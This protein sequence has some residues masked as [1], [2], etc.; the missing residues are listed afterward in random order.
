MT[1][2]QPSKPPRKHGWRWKDMTGQRIGRLVVVAEVRPRRVRYV[3]TKYIQT[4]TRW[5]CRCDC[6]KT[7]II[8]GITLRTGKVTSC[9]CYKREL[10]RQRM[11][12]H[13]LPA[14]RARYPQ[15]PTVKHGQA[16]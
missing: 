13:V 14:M 1:T 11:W 2:H 10:A 16:H 8:E 3:N 15:G 6:G 7:K 4:R 9:G 12:T 5:R